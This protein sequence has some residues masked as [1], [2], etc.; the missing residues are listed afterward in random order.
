MTTRVSPEVGTDPSRQWFGIYDGRV[1]N[2]RRRDLW[3]RVKVPQVLGDSKTDWAP[4]M[5]DPRQDTI[6]KGFGVFH[7]DPPDET[8]GPG[9]GPGIG[10]R[11][12]VMFIG[13]DINKP[14]YCLFGVHY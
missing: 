2:N 4:P 5:L 12:L 13:G 9:P 14:V 1:V 3:V 8:G 6:Y 11:V 10:S 7:V